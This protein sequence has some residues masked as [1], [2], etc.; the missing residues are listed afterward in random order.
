ML[1]RDEK[2][3][4]SKKWFLTTFA[5]ISVA[6]TNNA[7]SALA[8]DRTRVILNEDEISSSMSLTNQNKTLPFLAQAWIE[9]SEGEKINGPLTAIPPVQRVEAGAKSQVKVQQSIGIKSLPQD[10]ESVFYFNMREIPPKS[11]KPNTLQIALQSR[12]KLFYRPAALKVDQNSKPFQEDITLSKKENHY[13]VNN[14]TGYYITIS[15]MTATIK[16]NTVQGFNPVMVAPK[17]SAE[18][19]GNANMA[20]SNPVL[21]YIND[22]GGRPKIIFTCGSGSCKVTSTKAG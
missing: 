6:A 10:R 15:D 1:V 19:S 13:I 8:L 12:I 2:M 7:F 11:L 21:T 22:F 3:S 16:G 5:L 14:P 18:L 4:S 17:S 9:N 20:G